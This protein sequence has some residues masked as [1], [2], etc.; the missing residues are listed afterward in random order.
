MLSA[1]ALH[2]DMSNVMNKILNKETI[3]RMQSGKT[4][5]VQKL[6][7]ECADKRLIP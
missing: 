4:G 5:T 7:L 2:L 3:E 6:N 1:N